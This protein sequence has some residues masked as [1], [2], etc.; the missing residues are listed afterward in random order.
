MPGERSIG[1]ASLLTRP[2]ERTDRDEVQRAKV[3]VDG[4]TG[5]ASDE[6]TEYLP[7][8]NRVAV[9]AVPGDRVGRGTDECC[10]IGLAWYVTERADNSQRTTREGSRRPYANRAQSRLGRSDV[11]ARPVRE[12]DRV[13]V[14]EDRVAEH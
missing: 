7:C 8:A 9:G 4:R 13:A 5:H 1:V 6:V 2:R 11:D 14:D 3:V 10:L 12:H